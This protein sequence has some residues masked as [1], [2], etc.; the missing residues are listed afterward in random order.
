MLI[1]FHRSATP[2]PII[3]IKGHLGG[4]SQLFSLSLVMPFCKLKARA[5]FANILQKLSRMQSL[6][7]T[8]HTCLQHLVKINEMAVLK[9]YSNVYPFDFSVIGCQLFV[10]Q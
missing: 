9:K 3:G 6:L 1:R 7:I 10:V 5:T 4:N 2:L 8:Y